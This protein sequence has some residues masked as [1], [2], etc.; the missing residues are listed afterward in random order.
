MIISQLLSSLCRKDERIQFCLRRWNLALGKFPVWEG[1]CTRGIDLCI[2]FCSNPLS[3]CCCLYYQRLRY[4]RHILLP[5]LS[6]SPR[7]PNKQRDRHERV[8]Y[9]LLN[10]PL[11]CTWTESNKKIPH[12]NKWSD[13]LSR[14]PYSFSHFHPDRPCW[15]A[16]LTVAVGQRR[17]D[18]ERARV[19][20]LTRRC[21][22]NFWLEERRP[23][24]L[25]T[26]ASRLPLQHS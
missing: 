4:W 23:G 11:L 8:E 12:W 9:F 26:G 10:T 13:D 17:R 1:F 15:K 20:W 14:L 6:L 2:R 19:D 5:Q 7:C 21:S 25:Y 22:C 16:A 3:L 24:L 18:D